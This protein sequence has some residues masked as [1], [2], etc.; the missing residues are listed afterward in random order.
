MCRCL[1]NSTVGEEGGREGGFCFF[2][3]PL[4]R[5]FMNSKEVVVFVDGAGGWVKERE[6]FRGGWNARKWNLK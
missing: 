1:Q 5:C 6:Q 3:F 4:F 2:F